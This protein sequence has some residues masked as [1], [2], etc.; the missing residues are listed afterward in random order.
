M[1]N[2][3]AIP[4]RLRGLKLERLFAQ[5]TSRAGSPMPAPWSPPELVELAELFPGFEV[6]RL[7][8]RGGMGAVYEARQLA[9]ERRVAIKL[10]PV[11]AGGDAAFAERF[12]REARTLA[13]LQHP[14]IV[15]VFESGETSSGHLF[16]VME[17][18][19]GGDL[20]E[21]ARRGRF[22]PGEALQLVDEISSAL[23]C[24]HAQGVVHRDIK[25]S[26]ILLT[27]DGHAKVADFGLAVLADREPDS[28]LTL[29]GIAL[30]TF[31]YAAPEQLSGRGGE[32]ARSD[33]YSLGVLAYELLAGKPPRGVFDPPSLANPAVDP[34]V[35]AVVLTAMQ[36]E[37]ERRFQS[38]KDFAVA[39][40]RARDFRA[41]QLARE[42]ELRRKARRRTRLAAFGF[43]AAAAA[44]ALA[45]FAFVQRKAARNL[46]AEAQAHRRAAER[47]RAEAE[48][49]VDF[50]LSDMRKNAAS[51]GN[52]EQLTGVLAQVEK[53]YAQT[54]SPTEDAAF[55]ERKATFLS[56][57][58][59]TRKALGDKATAEV[60]YRRFVAFIE[61]LLARGIVNAAWHRA[62]SIAC[63][64]IGE[65]RA[66][67]GDVDGAREAVAHGLRIALD[68]RRIAPASV[69]TGMQVIHMHAHHGDLLL[70]AGLA[71]NAK[72]Q[73]QAAERVLDE[74]LAADATNGSALMMAGR[75]QS[76]LGALCETQGD[77]DSALTFYRK[78]EEFYE[79]S[80][81]LDS[82]E[83]RAQP[84][85][86]IG[87]VLLKMG[88]FA[89]AIP[90]LETAVAGEEKS[91][92]N[93][94]LDAIQMETTAYCNRVL[95]EALEPVGRMDEARA[96]KQRD[97]NLMQ[98]KD[99]LSAAVK[100]AASNNDSPDF[101]A[102][103]DALRAAPESVEAQFQWVQRSEIEGARIEKASGVEASLAHFRAQIA[104]IDAE[105]KTAP[106]DSWWLLGRSFASNRIGALEAGRKNWPAAEAAYRAGLDDRQGLIAAHPD[107]ARLARDVASAANHLVLTLLELN[108]AIEA[109]DLCRRTMA[110][111]R[112]HPRGNLAWRITLPRAAK[113]IAAKLDAP[114][115]DALLADAATFLTASA[116]E[117]LP[118]DEA[119]L[120]AEIRA[121]KN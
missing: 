48:A 13:R 71:D 58:A 80:R 60:E 101:A 31:D 102:A 14:H 5:A 70:N 97:D 111:L 62:A 42:R 107:T 15:A 63:G 116:G 35:D 99:E 36:S 66:A 115:A 8:G 87:V 22:E 44:V 3:A 2:D 96:A 52:L 106:A 61:P 65:I 73:F 16:F 34:A 120:L 28:K 83:N 113:S 9:L 25:P 33:L 74:L 40:N 67:A 47:A 88:R 49:L 69:E 29:T 43:L 27:A 53:Y 109:A 10:L 77:L 95:A 79:R 46:A 100:S 112:N 82:P 18:V 1:P 93:K 6:A 26:N 114:A 121:E 117:P 90:Y 23:A 91:L 119:H 7:I 68:W 32:D 92:V 59:E 81:V 51:G 20:A 78:M 56:I 94:P 108:R 86:H 72:A 75:I 110:Q 118:D 57:N 19:D 104:R 64:G 103:F 84:A 30:G 54:A 41:N 45:V 50:M 38:A 24:A 85:I 12:R 76:S 21:R 39:L 98:R 105:L 4:P 37:P 17:Y 89:E 55:L 11:E